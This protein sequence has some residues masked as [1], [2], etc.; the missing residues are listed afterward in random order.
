[1]DVVVS[2]CAE[3]EAAAVVEPGEGAFD[4]PALA[5]EAGAVSAL[6]ACDHRPDAELRDEATVLVVVVAAVG[7]QLLRPSSGA[8][9]APAHGWNAVEQLEQL[10]HV[11]A[12]RAGQRPGERE[13]T[14]VDEQV[15]LAARAS[16]VNRAGTRF[17]APLFACR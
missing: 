16:A 4:D 2:V 12:V 3:Q 7:K 6:A 17:R 10:R 5:T 15:V 14:A 13:P 1:M 11:V 8:T 9:A